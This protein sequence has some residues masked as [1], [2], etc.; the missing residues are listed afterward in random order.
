[1]GAYGVE[2]P[3]DVDPPRGVGGVE[4]AEDVLDVELCPAVGVGAGQGRGLGDGEVGRVA[5][6]SRRGGEDKVTNAGGLKAL[7]ERHASG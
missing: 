3:E 7:E 4:V 5:V 2:V 6:D 1:M